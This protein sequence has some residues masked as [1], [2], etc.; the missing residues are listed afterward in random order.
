M[1]QGKTGTFPNTDFH[2]ETNTRVKL[3]TH[4]FL[5]PLMLDALFCLFF[6]RGLK[7]AYLLMFVT[8]L[9][10]IT[11]AMLFIATMEKVVVIFRT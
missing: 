10:L 11:L 7:M 5:S 3:V 6:G 4:Y 8:L 9:H 2:C 1:F